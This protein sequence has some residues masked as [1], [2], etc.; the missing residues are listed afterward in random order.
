MS[1]LYASPNA[2]NLLLGAGQ[3]YFNRYLSDTGYYVGER[4]L[5]NVTDFTF[6]TNVEMFE[7]YSSMTADRGLY[8]SAPKQTRG[9]GK[10]VMDE[11]D[12]YNLC[13]GLLGTHSVIQQTAGTVLPAAAETFLN[14]SRGQAIKLGSSGT[15]KFFTAS[16]GIVVTDSAGTTTYVQDRDYIVLSEA[17]GMIF[18][19]DNELSIFPTTASTVKVS[20]GYTAA[21]IREIAGGTDLQIEGYLRFVGDPTAGPGYEGEFWNVSIIPDGEL[22]FIG[23]DQKPVNIT[24]E[25]QDDTMN[26]PT[27]PFYRLARN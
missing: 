12:P 24:F 18:F 27:E 2:E 25:C 8:F 10:L 23:D 26:H 14:V 16:S 5:G 3:I 19:P 1:K 7:K 17:A 21:T 20:Y 15:Q 11:Y 13:L 9:S 22:T 4:H 6:N